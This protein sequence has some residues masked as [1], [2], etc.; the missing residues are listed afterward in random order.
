M[1]L[2]EQYAEV[3]IPLSHEATVSAQVMPVQGLEG[4]D[5]GE[6]GVP[7]VFVLVMA[8]NLCG[9]ILFITYNSKQFLAQM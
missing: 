8:N 3:I 5:F 6:E 2:A 4:H 9:F 7:V 1:P